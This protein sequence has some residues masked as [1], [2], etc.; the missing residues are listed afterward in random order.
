[1]KIDIEH[2]TETELVDLN[3]RIVEQLRF[4]RLMRAHSSMFIRYYDTPQQKTVSVL[5]DNRP[6]R[7]DAYAKPRTSLDPD[8]NYMIT[9]IDEL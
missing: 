5:A 7:R 8:S 3:T 1:M 4:L 9:K 6:L 2:L